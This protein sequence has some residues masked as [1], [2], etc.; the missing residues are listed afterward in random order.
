MFLRAKADQGWLDPLEL[1]CISFAG[2]GVAG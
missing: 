1:L 2:L